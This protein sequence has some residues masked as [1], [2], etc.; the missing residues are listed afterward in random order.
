[1]YNF[2]LHCQKLC[3]FTGKKSINN[4]NCLTVGRDD[5]CVVLF[6]QIFLKTN[7]S[8]LGEISRTSEKKNN[9]KT[10]IINF[11]GAKQM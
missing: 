9:N 1:M 2:K 4:V 8:R 10:I 5:S 11:G 7:Y 6:I 3:C